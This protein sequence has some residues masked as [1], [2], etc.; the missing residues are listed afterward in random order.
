VPELDD[1]V[2]SKPLI[3][4]EAKQYVTLKMICPKTYTKH[5]KIK[6]S[7]ITQKTNAHVK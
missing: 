3:K 5:M 4:Y 6:K 1:K 2:N 7:Y